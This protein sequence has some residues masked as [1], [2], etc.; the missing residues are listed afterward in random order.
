MYEGVHHT[1]SAAFRRA[2][3]VLCVLE[4][5]DLRFTNHAQSMLA[6]RNI[7]KAWVERTVAEPGLRSQDPNDI[8]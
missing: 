8:E 1:L 6:N 7:P 5:P 4:L 2:N 3:L